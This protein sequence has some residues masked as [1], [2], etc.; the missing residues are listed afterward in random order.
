[1]SVRALTRTLRD[2]AL[3]NS[4]VPA[5]L[6]RLLTAARDGDCATVGRLTRADG[7][8]CLAT[9]TTKSDYGDAR[10]AAGASRAERP[11]NWC[12]LLLG[13]RTNIFDSHGGMGALHVAA[14]A[15]HLSVVTLLLAA[16]APAAAGLEAG[17]MPP[18]LAA[19]I[20]QTEVAET[21]LESCRTGPPVD[22]AAYRVEWALFVAAERRCLVLVQLLLATDADLRY[23]DADGTKALQKAAG[24]RHED[25]LRLVLAA[26]PREYLRAED[27]AG[28][29]PLKVAEECNLP[30][31][32]RCSKR[33]PPRQRCLRS[34]QR[35]SSPAPLL[36]SCCEASRRRTPRMTYC[37]CLRWRRTGT[38]RTA[39]STPTGSSVSWLTPAASTRFPASRS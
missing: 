14:F 10:E 7:A 13:P 15:G 21:L 22:A 23:I 18:V 28:R 35:W 37:R 36:R 31:A 1:M 25:V 2:L 27:R 16:G 3:S 24:T 12:E 38:F 33:P 4:P 19:M 26:V 34:H 9:L 29:T 6:L 30:Y 5:N 17:T 20:D 32:V 8:L 39:S 11:A